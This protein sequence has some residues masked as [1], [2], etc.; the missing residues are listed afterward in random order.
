[1]GV[2]LDVLDQDA[3]AFYRSF[4]FFLPL[5]DNPMKLF[6]PIASLESL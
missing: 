5:T 1:M 3:L 4:D 6:V 2:V